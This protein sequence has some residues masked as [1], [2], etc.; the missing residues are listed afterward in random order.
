MLPAANVGATSATRKN[1]PRKNRLNSRC[2][3][4]ELTRWTPPSVVGQ[5]NTAT[6]ANRTKQTSGRKT[7]RGERSV[8]RSSGPST[9]L[10]RRIRAA[11]GEDFPAE[12]A[13]SAER[14]EK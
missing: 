4:P 6:T 12:D 8:T 14:S 11:L 3:A 9:G 13:E 10:S 2:A 7:D 1:C 5:A